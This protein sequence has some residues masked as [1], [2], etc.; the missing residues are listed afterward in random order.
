MVN[1]EWAIHG[2]FVGYSQTIR[3]YRVCIGYVSG[4]YR[5]S[6]GANNEQRGIKRAG[7]E[8]LVKNFVYVVFF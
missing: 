7:G 8:L 5:V 2:V 6:I 3:M 4:M 1:T